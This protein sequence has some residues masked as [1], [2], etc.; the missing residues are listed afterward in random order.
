M[1]ESIKKFCTRLAYY[2]FSRNHNPKNQ[3]PQEL[4]LRERK[5]DAAT[6][7]VCGQFM[8]ASEILVSQVGTPL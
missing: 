3:R 6:L 1:L 2:L 5:N 8:L 7:E 4:Y